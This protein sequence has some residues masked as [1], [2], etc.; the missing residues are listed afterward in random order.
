MSHS[1]TL[2]KDRHC[3]FGLFVGGSDTG[4]FCKRMH[5]L[6]IFSLSL[7]AVQNQWINVSA[8]NSLEVHQ[9]PK[10][11]PDCPLFTYLLSTLELFPQSSLTHKTGFDE[12]L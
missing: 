10:E 7:A 12:D 1:G 4:P 2:V 6:M 11:K 9:E 5:I 3:F 8:S